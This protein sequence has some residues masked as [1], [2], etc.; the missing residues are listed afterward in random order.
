MEQE[1][2]FIHSGISPR[3]RRTKFDVPKL[4]YP[5]A[6]GWKLPRSRGIS[7][8]WSDLSM[9]LYLSQYAEKIQFIDMPMDIIPSRDKQQAGFRNFRVEDFEFW[10]ELL[11]PTRFRSV[12]ISEPLT[13]IF[14]VRTKLSRRENSFVHKLHRRVVDTCVW[15]IR[16]R[17]IFGV[18]R[19]GSE[20]SNQVG[21]SEETSLAAWIIYFPIFYK[22]YYW[23][24][25]L[26]IDSFLEQS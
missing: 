12:L 15:N 26:G 3:I 4:G 20:V 19:S 9:R 1:L 24:S 25:Q 8:T 13:P 10:A 16:V 7:K 5:T 17:I 21:R 6:V 11:F 22:Y 18:S 2:E 23:E 14:G